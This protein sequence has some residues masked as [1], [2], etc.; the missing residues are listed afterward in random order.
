VGFLVTSVFLH[1]AYPRLFWL[2]LGLALIA[3]WPIL[4]A[5]RS[6][7]LRAVEA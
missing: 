5:P 3:P 4:Q 6:E 7:R 2:L 1:G